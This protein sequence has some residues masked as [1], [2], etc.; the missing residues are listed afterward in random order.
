MTLVYINVNN[1]INN[2]KHVY[3][4]QI[5]LPAIMVG[6]WIIILNVL[7]IVSNH[8]LEILQLINVKN[9]NK[10]AITVQV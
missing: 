2:V 10:I 6:F 8:I 4:Q 9:V 1:A 5:V 3:H 7:R